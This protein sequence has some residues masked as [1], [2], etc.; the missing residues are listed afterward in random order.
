MKQVSK[1]ALTKILIIA[2]VVYFG[3]TI[4]SKS[5]TAAT[6]A[7]SKIPV[8]GVLLGWILKIIASPIK[9]LSKVSKVVLAVD[10]IILVLLIISFFVRKRKQKETIE[11][12][13]NA[14]TVEDKKTA[15]TKMM[16]AFK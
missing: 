8:L 2:N 15:F 9:L 16:D 6:A 5:L 3:L 13:A 12:A 10:V 4:L 11:G 7:V 14:T 1:F